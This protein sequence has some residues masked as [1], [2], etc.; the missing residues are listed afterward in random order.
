MRTG[1]DHIGRG[2]TL[3][4]LLVVIGIVGVL[5][6]LILPAL[7]GARGSALQTVALSNARSV[8]TQFEQHAG[9]HGTYPQQDLGEV[10]DGLPGGSQYEP[11][12]DEVIIPW[13]PGGVVIASTD[14][15]Q[16]EWMWAA[17]VA[18]ID[19]WPTYWET[20]VS[21]RKDQALPSLDDVT[22]DGQLRA[23]DMISIRYAHGFVA[24]PAYF[25]G[26]QA[27]VDTALLRAVRPHD[28]RYASGKVMLWDNDLS[29]IPPRDRPERV[30]G[31]LEA[32]TPM[33]FADGHADALLPGEASEPVTNVMTG[34]AIRLHGTRDG[35][36]GRDY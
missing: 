14:Y 20:W 36:H 1:N 35:V 11:R 8:H 19:D 5:I 25:S 9:Q 12:G 18:P 23:Q 16:H 2:F 13:Y 28:V 30:N 27:G 21:P 33:A 34:E 31:L 32:K 17:M 10:P 24:R 22:L 6:G 3:V 26:E 7:S 29:Y 4:E 15:F